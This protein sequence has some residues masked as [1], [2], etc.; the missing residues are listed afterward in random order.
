MFWLVPRPASLN[1][2]VSDPSLFRVAVALMKCGL[3]ASAAGTASAAAAQTAARTTS[4]RRIWRILLVII[5]SPG[6]A[7]GMQGLRSGR[8][9]CLLAARLVNRLPR[10]VALGPSVIRPLAAVA[11]PEV[12]V[13][14]GR[15]RRDREGGHG[16]N[17]RKRLATH[18]NHLLVVLRRVLS[19]SAEV[20]RRGGQNCGQPCSRPSL[21]ARYEAGETAVFHLLSGMTNYATARWPAVEA[22]SYVICVSPIGGGPSR[23]GNPFRV[24]PYGRSASPGKGIFIPH[25]A[26]KPAPL[27]PRLLGRTGRRRRVRPRRGARDR[28]GCRG[29]R[30]FVRG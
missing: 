7:M 19:G 24:R 20:S 13:S 17:R 9:Y 14:K 6:W 1:D 11:R 10:R 4:I 15:R 25:G 30:G 28:I 22:F 18:A 16:E 2:T 5:C 8:C 12:R 27:L 23:V 26:G 3:A 21:S 29:R